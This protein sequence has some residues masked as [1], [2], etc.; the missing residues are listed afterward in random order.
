MRLPA[1][2]PDFNPIEKLWSELKKVLRDAAARTEEALL[3]AIEDVL[4][5]ITATDCREGF[6][7]CGDP[8]APAN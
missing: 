4:E 8:P 3:R 6:G 5:Q 7:S 1:Y 2:G